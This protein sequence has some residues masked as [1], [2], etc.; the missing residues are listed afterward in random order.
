M[1]VRVQDHVTIVRLRSSSLT[2][3]SEIGRLTNA[4]ERMI[5][6]G[7]R[8]LIIDFKLVEHVGSTGLGM[9]IA[10]Q[11]K[12]KDIGGRLVV[13]HPEHLQDLLKVSHTTRLFELAVDSK[14]AFKL[15]KPV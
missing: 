8:R 2:S 14:A 11:K 5:A 10:L 13:S 12:M 6:E 4:F 7:S 3:M 15:L 9:L 1:L